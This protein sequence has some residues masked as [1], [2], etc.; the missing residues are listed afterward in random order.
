VRAGGGKAG[1]FR[2]LC[3]WQVSGSLKVFG[4]VF[5]ARGA[6]YGWGFQAA[7]LYRVSGSLKAF[8]ADVLVRGAHPTGGV[9]RLPLLAWAA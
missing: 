4:R 2:L 3:C 9:F 7:F 6:P 5:G 1:A 8:G